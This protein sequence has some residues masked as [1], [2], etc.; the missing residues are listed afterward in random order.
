MVDTFAE[1]EP[2][3]QG[4]FTCWCQYTN[5]R[6]CNNG[7]RIDYCLVD[8]ALFDLVVNPNPP[9]S[10]YLANIVPYGCVYN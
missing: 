7:A 3:A 9:N 5:D 4:R 2:G 6:Y 8:R 1:L 10:L